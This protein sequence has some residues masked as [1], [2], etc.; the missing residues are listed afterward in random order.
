MAD[1]AVRTIFSSVVRGTWPGYRGG[2]EDTARTSSGRVDEMDEW[3]TRRRIVRAVEDCIRASRIVGGIVDMVGGQSPRWREELEPSA[4][5]QTN[6][7]NSRNVVSLLAVSSP[8]HSSALERTR[9][10]TVLLPSLQQL[11]SD[12]ECVPPGPSNTSLFAR[13]DP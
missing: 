9:I 13:C 11:E 2:S 12:E 6:T 4:P 1:P 10:L 7:L 8:T 3:D 5:P